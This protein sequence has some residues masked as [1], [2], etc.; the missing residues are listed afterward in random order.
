MRLKGRHWVGLWLLAFLCAAVAVV[1]RQ[2]AAFGVARRL[3]ALREE[4]SGLEARRAELERRIR[5]ASS[6]PVLVPRVARTL[7]LQQP[8]DSEFVL[9]AVPAPAAGRPR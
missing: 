7:G 2:A 6:R 1:A 9:F 8:A 5:E 3:H 4:R